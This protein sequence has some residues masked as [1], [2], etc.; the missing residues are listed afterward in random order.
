MVP[1]CRNKSPTEL[2]DKEGHGSVRATVPRAAAA[3]LRAHPTLETAVGNGLLPA[4]PAA[5]RWERGAGC[6]GSSCG[7]RVC[8]TPAEPRSGGADGGE[9]SGEERRE[10]HR[11]QRT[12]VFPEIPSEIP[13]C[14]LRE[15]HPLLTV[16]TKRHVSPW[17]SRYQ[18]P[19]LSSAPS[20]GIPGLGSSRTGEA[21]G[22]PCPQPNRIH[23]KIKETHL[24]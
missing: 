5:L 14:P 2:R 21:G 17:H 10:G 19:P 13:V 7:T 15:D 18:T 4:K 6:A 20:R 3:P 24:N 16:A 22:F 12:S 23:P 1:R 11:E 8:S 9:R